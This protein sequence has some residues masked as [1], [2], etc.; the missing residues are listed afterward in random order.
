[1]SCAT[2]LRCAISVLW[3]WLAI[4]PVTKV[5]PV[6]QLGPRTQNMAHFFIHA[7]RKVLA[8]FLPATLYQ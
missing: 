4:D 2:C 1:M 6:L 7:L 8:A 5:L 3:L